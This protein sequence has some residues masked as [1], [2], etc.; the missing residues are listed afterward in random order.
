MDRIMKKY[1][2]VFDILEEYDRTGILNI[3]EDAKKKSELI[4]E[5]FS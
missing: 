2:K 1:K 4:E 3:S 5:R